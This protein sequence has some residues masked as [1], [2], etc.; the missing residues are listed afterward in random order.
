MTSDAATKVYREDVLQIA[1]LPIGNFL[2]GK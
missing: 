2:A 1:K